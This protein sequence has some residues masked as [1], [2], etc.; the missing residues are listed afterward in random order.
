MALAYCVN[1]PLF[2]KIQIYKFFEVL[3]NGTLY[4]SFSMCTIVCACV[5]VYELFRFFLYVF[6]LRLNLLKTHHPL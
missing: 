4:V 3:Q 5:C 2:I 1:T 6:S